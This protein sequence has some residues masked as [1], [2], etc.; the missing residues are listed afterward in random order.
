MPIWD[1]GAKE[2]SAVRAEMPAL[3]SAARGVKKTDVTLTGST[4]Q[5]A[6]GWNPA[7]RS[8]TF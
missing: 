8:G 2:E 3:W 6:D 4:G 7:D 5:L 1:R